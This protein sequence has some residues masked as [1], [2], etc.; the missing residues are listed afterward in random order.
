MSKRFDIVEL[1]VGF[2]PTRRYRCLVGASISTRAVRE[3]EWSSMAAF[4]DGWEKAFADS[5]HQA[6]VGELGS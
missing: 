5:E 6:L 2:P 3:R 4:E 1:A